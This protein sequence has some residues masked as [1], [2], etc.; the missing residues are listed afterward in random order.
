MIRYIIGVSVFIIAA[1][2]D[3]YYGIKEPI[4]YFVLGGISILI[5]Y[6]KFFQ[7]QSEILSDPFVS[8]IFKNPIETSAAP[9]HALRLTVRIKE[10]DV[11]VISNQQP[12]TSNLFFSLK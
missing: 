9:S 5:A 4:I 6:K 2:I 12:A 11:I 10:M 7:F 1:I 8:I 3:V